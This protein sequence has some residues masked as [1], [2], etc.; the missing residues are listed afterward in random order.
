MEYLHIHTSRGPS[1][2]ARSV[3]MAVVGHEKRNE[4]GVGSRFSVLLTLD[5]H[6]I[7]ESVALLHSLRYA[8]RQQE[9]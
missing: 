1:T 5:N 8:D 9:R 3:A 4:Q 7:S 2:I 6:A